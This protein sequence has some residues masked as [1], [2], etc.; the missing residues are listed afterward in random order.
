MMFKSICSQ[1]IL[2]FLLASFSSIR[3]CTVQAS[4]D[5]VVEVM[6]STSS[7]DL[8]Q[9]F[10]INVI[11]IDVQNLYGVEATVHWNAS[12]LQLANFDIRFGQTDGVLYKPYYP[13]NSSQEDQ[14]SVAGTSESP[15]L[16]FNGSGNILRITFNVT[17]SGSTDI[18]LEAQLYDYPPLDR[19]PRV[20]WP[21][22][23]TTNGGK[24]GPVVLEISDS[25]IL[26]VLAVLTAP[27]LVLSKKMARKRVFACS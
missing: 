25:T 10:T 1:I 6:P 17:S 27:A 4:P 19:E 13:I 2:V 15:A 9:T 7:A 3:T 11:V 8:G 22:Q 24:L 23:H 21:I 16:P 26:I 20:S 5:T 14:V 18:D 12:I